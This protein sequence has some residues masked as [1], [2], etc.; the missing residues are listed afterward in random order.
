MRMIK[1]PEGLGAELQLFPT[2]LASFLGCRHRTGLDLSAAAGRL[3]PPQWT[4]AMAEALK[5]RGA[6]HE[7]GY[8]DSLKQQ[9]LA[10]FEARIQP[11]PEAA[12]ERAMRDGAEVIVQAA[13]G[14]DPWFG[15]A[16]VLRRVAAPSRL[17]A[18]SYEV[19]DTKLART[20]AGRTILQLALYSELVAGVQGREPE[21]F[22]VITPDPQRAQQSF[23]YAEHAAYYRLVKRRFLEAVAGGGDALVAENY[24]DPV[25]ECEMCRWWP[26][27]DTRRRADDHLGFIAGIGRIQRVELAGQGIATL[28]AAAGLALPVPFAPRRGA[29]ETYTRIREQAR[30]QREQRVLGKPVYELLEVAPGLGLAS[31]PA[32]SRGDLFLD[33]EGAH[34]AREGGREYLFGVWRDGGYEAWWARDDAGEKAAFAAFIDCAIER[35]RDDPAMHIY[36]YGQYEPTALKR[37]MGRHATR[38][39][40]LDHLLRNDRFVDLFA[41]VHH[42]VRAGVESYSIKKLEQFY[43]FRREVEL[44]DANVNLR[45]VELAVESGADAELPAAA[46]AAVAG[47]NRDDCRSTEA[48]RGW[49]ETLRL[50]LL[51]RGIEVPRPAPKAEAPPEA[52]RALDA[53][54]E[55]LRARILKDLPD[56]ASDPQH[57]QHPCWL[58]AYL[59]D[60]HRREAKAAWW[61]YFRV[62]GLGDA[63]L[64]F[65]PQAIVGARFVARSL[66]T[67]T[68]TGKPTGSF[69]DSYQYPRQEIELSPG[70]DLTRRDESPLGA[71]VAHDRAA[72]TIEVKHTSGA[73]DRDPGPLFGMRVFRTDVAQRVVMAIANHPDPWTCGVQLLL[74]EKPRLLSRAPFARSVFD[75]TVDDFAVRVASDLDRSVLAVQGPPGSGKTT[76]GARMIL[77]L[78]RAGKRVGVTAVSHKVVRNLLDA[79]AKLARESGMSVELGHKNGDKD[80]AV[81]AAATGTVARNGAAQAT[82]SGVANNASGD[83]RVACA[84]QLFDDNRKALEWLAA[85]PRA[86]G[87]TVWLWS[88]DAARAT[89]D[90]LFVDEAGQMSLANVLA[91]SRA[92]D[93]LVLLGD[94]N[95]LEQ[96]Q[97]GTHPDG[98]GVSALEHIL[99]RART[100]PPDHGIF[101]PTTYRLAPDLC[102]FTSE[103]FYD[104]KLHPEPGRERQQLVGTRGFDGSGLWMAPI[105]HDHNKNWSTEEVEAVSAIVDRLLANEYAP[106]SGERS[107]AASERAF[108][109]S[110]ST[111]GVSE[112]ASGVSE[113]ASVTSESASVAEEGSA[114]K[115]RPHWV[116]HHGASHPLTG[117]DILVVAPYNAQVNRLT[118]RLRDRGVSVG[119]VDK[120]QGQEAPVVIYSMATS[121]AEDAPR[122]MEFLY[123]LNRLNVATSRARCAAIVVASPLLFQPDCQTPRQIQLANALCRFAELAREANHELELQN[124]A[125]GGG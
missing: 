18:W 73:I 70:S 14:S 46:A 2:D 28:D 47:Y 87:G 72:R 67:N 19:V 125:A 35:F 81:P 65:E 44:G 107:S 64:E 25:G 61:E 49:L 37:L 6:Q 30:L 21:S 9:G 96:P 34:F 23:R 85:G 7:R 71:V 48:L 12:T 116:D 27:C 50:E 17:G 59:I 114:L 102:R 77:S 112:S 41:V 92:A 32:P 120:F 74:R 62:R 36:H 24:P 55:A 29:R 69:I 42:G 83:G 109:V 80:G 118:E 13:L 75:A 121:R 115:G 15:Y 51:Q 122:G 111:S 5:E 86:L 95:Q 82:A 88:S 110:E 117:A 99:G 89:V 39:E 1:D 52:V 11:D 119:T 90:V 3:Q 8:I 123:S 84:V 56:S 78:L 63:E 124:R 4:D 93:S 31:L 54:V 97:K 45:L 22:H 57:P 108:G 79:V 100:M 66:V 98:V 10:V 40:E 58:L 68:K 16:D 26:R 105:P 103:A 38:C 33:L 106:T 60:W 43:G 104:G 76:L 20:T 101:L 94:P 113:S 91:A 53:E